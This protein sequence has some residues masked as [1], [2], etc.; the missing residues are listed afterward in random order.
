MVLSFSW[1]CKSEN[2]EMLVIWLRHPVLLSPSLLKS[3]PFWISHDGGGLNSTSSGHVVIL[4]SPIGHFRGSKTSP[5]IPNISRPPW[6]CSDWRGDLSDLR[7]EVCHT[8]GGPRFGTKACCSLV[9]VWKACRRGKGRATAWNHPWCSLILHNKLRPVGPGKAAQHPGR[10]GIDPVSSWVCKAEN[11][12]FSE[13]VRM[14]FALAKA[15]RWW[16]SFIFSQDLNFPSAENALPA[17]WRFH[18]FFATLEIWYLL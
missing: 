7:G 11:R 15:W 1:A 3:H 2:Q 6:T 13:N 4:E 18:Q 8:F 12:K 16:R 9:V 14:D 17:E 5:K 10:R